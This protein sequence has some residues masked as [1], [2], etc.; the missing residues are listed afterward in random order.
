LAADLGATGFAAAGSGGDDG[1][2]ELG[3]HYDAEPP[4]I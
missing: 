3:F 4:A 2:V 1:I